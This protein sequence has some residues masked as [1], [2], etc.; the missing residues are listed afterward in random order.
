MK[1]SNPLVINNRP[2]YVNGHFDLNRDLYLHLHF[3]LNWV[4]YVYRLFHKDWFINNNWVFIDWFLDKNLF[5]DDFR[6]FYFFYY[7]LW[8]LFLD[9]NVFRDFNYPFGDSLRPRYVLW[10]FNFYLDRPLHDHLS[11]SL[12]G[13]SPIIIFDFFL[14]HLVFQ[15]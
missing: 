2:I 3:F 9:L 14:K 13:I 15:F 5:L 10:D 4:I 8:D 12:F 11:N 7:D 1:P 6:H